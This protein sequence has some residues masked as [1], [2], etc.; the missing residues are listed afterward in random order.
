MI[1]SAI[2]FLKQAPQ[3]NGK[4]GPDRRLQES[5]PGPRLCGWQTRVTAFKGP[6][7]SRRCSFQAA[8]MVTVKGLAPKGTRLKGKV[9][10]T[11]G[12][13]PG[14]C[15]QMRTGQLCCLSGSPEVTGRG[16]QTDGCR[17]PLILRAVGP[18]APATTVLCLYL[19]LSSTGRGT[20]PHTPTPPVLPSL[21]NQ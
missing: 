6:T 19:V 7:T 17:S 11:E 16:L 21:S 2:C 10:G 20:P 8:L 18:L 5:H 13:L 1:P 4:C 9:N 14:N 15:L 12:K 3:N